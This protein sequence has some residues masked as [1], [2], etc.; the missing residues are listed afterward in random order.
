MK[1]LERY[2]F[3]SFLTSF[4]LAFLVLSFVLTI[5]L[6]VQITS[7]IL[8]GVPLG[9]VGRFALV[10]FP[11]TMQW[12]IPLGLLVSSVLVFSRMSADSEVAAMRACGVNIMSVIKWPLCFAAACTLLGIVINNEVVP[13]G[14]EIRRRLAKRIT[15][16]SGL[17]ILQPGRIIDEFPKAKAY[18]DRKEGNWLY[19]L[20]V[21]DLR[22]PKIERLYT[23]SKA[24]VTQRGRDILL[25]LH[26][27]T[28]E[29]IDEHN[30]GMAHARRVPVEIKDALKDS[31]YKVREKD[32][33]FW[34]IL[35]A[36][37]KADRDAEEAD[38]DARL[39]RLDKDDAR[40]QAARH[41][42]KSMRKR[43]SEL[44]TEFMKRFVF[45]FASICFVLVGVPLGIRAQ[46][47]ESSIGMAVSLAVALGYYLVTILMGALDKNP[48]LHPW[49][50]IWLPVAIC[51][52]LAARL[53][54]KNL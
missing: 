17:D 45:A 5:G 20:V 37:F 35:K 38:R 46:R 9:L 53:I 16:G 31:R 4:I 19:G 41:M 26:D 50:F 14:H 32:L 34:D 3:G 24:M 8:D 42:K 10:C 6:M 54:P 11:E 23:A 25:D 39:A 18:F 15:V 21:K 51:F 13:R 49:Y 28:I 30:P 48:E 52:L 27:V 12:T 22:D 7:Y 43:A 2:V 33:C 44:K 29:P 1:T 36:I 40:A 47:K